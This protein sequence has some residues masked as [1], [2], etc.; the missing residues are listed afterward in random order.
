MIEYNGHADSFIE[1][2][3][4]II[5]AFTS[6]DG[7]SNIDSKVV[8][9]FGNEWLKFSEFEEQE[10]EKIGRDYFDIIDTSIVNNESIVLDAGCGTGRWSKVLCKKVKFIEAFDPS[11]AV[12][13]ANHLLRNDKNIRVTK[14]NIDTI[15]FADNEFDLVMSIGVL[16]HIPN[17]QNALMKLVKKIKSGGYFYGYL[18]YDFENRGAL[19]KILFR[20]S[21]LLR[22]GISNSPSFIKKAIC[23]F[24]ALFIYL[25]LAKIAMIVK[26]VNKSN[27][28][29]Q[30]IPLSY[31]HDKSFM[32]M[33]NDSLDRFGT[34]LEKRYA[35]SNIADLLES[36]G[37]TNVKFSDREPYWHFTAQKL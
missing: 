3:S 37:L 31:Y 19:F 6:F 5:A 23:D 10:L 26:T 1:T 32:I 35:K 24:I 30:K 15:P 4:G 33:R 2:D 25:P 9:D 17:T 36:C 13:A 11:A 27:F 8:H 12:F 20:I 16:H 22:K 21:D 28:A 18:Y 29:Y 34:R 7:K 14:A